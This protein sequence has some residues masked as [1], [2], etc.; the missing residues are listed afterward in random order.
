VSDLAE[1]FLPGWHRIVS[2]KDREGLACAL[3][4]D[5]SLGSPPYWPRFEGREI[6]HHLLGLILDTVEGFTYHR[7]WRDGAELALEFRGRVAGL[8]LQGIDLVTLNDRLEIQRL[9]VLIR[10]VHAVNALQET[11]APRMTAFLAE[12]AAAGS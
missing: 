9:D 3:A 5:V 10:P 6:V 4:E 7:E 12:R 2:E 8:E 1:R 11:I